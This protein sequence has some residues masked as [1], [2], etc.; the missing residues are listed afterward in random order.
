MT[1]QEAYNILY[2][3]YPLS[4]VNACLDYGN[5]YVF[6]LI[7]ADIPTGETY[8]TGTIFDAVDKRTGKVFKYDITSNIDAYEN[9]KNVSV[10]DIFSQKI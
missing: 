7:P 9:A 4:R 6:S 2:K 8:Y 1:P 3:H 10:V 5:F